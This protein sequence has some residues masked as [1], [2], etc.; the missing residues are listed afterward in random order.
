MSVSQRTHPPPPKNVSLKR[1][2]KAGGIVQWSTC[3]P[4]G[5]GFDHQ[6]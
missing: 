2:L 5:S 6:Y 1:D 4:C 3:L